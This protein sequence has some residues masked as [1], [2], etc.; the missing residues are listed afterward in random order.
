MGYDTLLERANDG[1]LMKTH[2]SDGSILESFWEKQELEGY[3]WSE[4]NTIHVLRWF[5]HAVVKIKESGEIV[6]LTSN[7]RHHLNKIG[8]NIEV[9][10]DKDYFFEIFGTP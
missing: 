1:I 5:D 7:A 2:F 3:N 4:L 8:M 10:R 9:P 6:L